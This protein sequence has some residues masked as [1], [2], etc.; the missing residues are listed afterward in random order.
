MLFGGQASGSLDGSYCPVQHV[1]ELVQTNG[2]STTISGKI[3]LDPRYSMPA[4][5]ALLHP[6]DVNTNPKR[7][8]QTRPSEPV[9]TRRWSHCGRISLAPHVADE[10]PDPPIGDTDIGRL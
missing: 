6:S 3:P 5:Q 10:H 9:T 4:A 7:H 8:S 1:G 2:M